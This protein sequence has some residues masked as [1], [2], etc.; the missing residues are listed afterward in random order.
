M[1]PGSAASRG[2]C[3]GLEGQGRRW[4]QW[5]PPSALF[6]G[7]LWSMDCATELVLT[8]GTQGGGGASCVLTSLQAAPQGRKSY[9]PTHM[10]TPP[11]KG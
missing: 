8:S 3:R 10:G 4:P 7:E 11:V 9:P 5:S 1:Y 6:H 2:E